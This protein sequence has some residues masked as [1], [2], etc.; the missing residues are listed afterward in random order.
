M[1]DRIRREDPT[2]PIGTPLTLARP[3]SAMEK[4]MLRH[5]IRSLVLVGWSKP[6]GYARCKDD[7][8]AIWHIHPE[9]LVKGR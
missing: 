9:A 7:L 3:L 6:H 5:G 8:G 1:I 4:D 2:V